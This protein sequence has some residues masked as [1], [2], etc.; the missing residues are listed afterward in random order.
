[1][2]KQYV[3]EVQKWKK[4]LLDECIYNIAMWPY[5]SR[6]GSEIM[7]LLFREQRQ[8]RGF[9]NCHVILWTAIRHA[10][11]LRG[12]ITYRISTILS[13]GSFKFV[14]LSIFEFD[15]IH[16]FKNGT[17]GSQFI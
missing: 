2:N 7:F 4:S 12:M 13:I 5:H 17:F 6:A 15:S 14:T 3:E 1:M 9:W 10:N 11:Y 8:R 16:K